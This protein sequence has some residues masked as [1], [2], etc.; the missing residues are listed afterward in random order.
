M[1]KTTTF[2]LFI[3]LLCTSAVAYADSSDSIQRYGESTRTPLSGFKLDEAWFQTSYWAVPHD[4]KAMGGLKMWEI[5]DHACSWQMQ[6]R[7]L[8]PLLASG[9]WSRKIKAC[10]SELGKSPKT[11]ELGAGEYVEGIQICTNQRK[12]DK[13]TRLKGVR[14]FGARVKSD[15]TVQSGTSQT[16]FHRTNCKVWRQKA[17]CPE[18]QLA[19]AA[20]FYEGKKGVF[21]N[22]IFGVELH[23]QAVRKETSV[24][25]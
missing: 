13:K 5:A 12:N 16:E 8:T 22:G 25:R 9:E 6:Y 4:N 19:Y 11:V 23:C 20:T 3:G 2:A 18:G 14:L 7:K 15:G 1:R 21:T 10:G 24:H 17:M